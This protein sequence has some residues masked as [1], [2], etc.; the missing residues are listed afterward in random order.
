MLR[1]AAPSCA[2]IPEVSCKGRN[3]QNLARRFQSWQ[4]GI[5][6]R[7]PQVMD[8]DISYRSLLVNYK[9]LQA[10]WDEILEVTS[11]NE[12]KAKI[13]GFRH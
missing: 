6:S 5:K 1:R 4:S 11:D 8:G 3:I 7:V 10:C 9:A 2:P 13:I 12:T